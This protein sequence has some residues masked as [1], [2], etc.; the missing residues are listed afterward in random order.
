MTTSIDFSTATQIA[1]CSIAVTGNDAATYLQGQVTADIAAITGR[2]LVLE[3]SSEV[4]SDFHWRRRDDG[5][6]LVIRD[7]MVDSVLTRLRRFALRI[8]VHFG[9]PVATEGPYDTFAEQWLRGC[10]GPAEFYCGLTPRSF[11][12]ALVASTVSFTKGCY[13]GQELVGRLDARNANVPFHVVRFK[14]PTAIDVARHF[15]VG[16]QGGMQ[17]VTSS[18]VIDGESY[19]FAVVH[20]SLDIESMSNG[21]VLVEPLRYLEAAS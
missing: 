12:E 3:P 21:G 18:A 6:D 19:G 1:W 8:D 4:I 14:A 15:H 9:E 16:P 10:P 20:R 17:G 5:I 7:E 11:G 2:G 13:T